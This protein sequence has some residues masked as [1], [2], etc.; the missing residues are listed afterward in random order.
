MLLQ[1]ESGKKFRDSSTVEHLAVNQR[2][3]G[4]N[5]TRGAERQEQDKMLLP[6]FVSVC[7]LDSYISS[8]QNSCC[9]TE[10]K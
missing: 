9:G 8:T 6:F 1:T 3:V 4:S 10:N 2:V 7:L 5:P